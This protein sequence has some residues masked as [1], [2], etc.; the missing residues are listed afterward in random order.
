MFRESNL[1]V[2]K[3]GEFAGYGA[4]RHP[5]GSIDFNAYRKR[6]RQ[7]RAAAIKS[8]LSGAWSL[9]ANRLAGKAAP[10]AGRHATGC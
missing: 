5:D 7:A 9:L 10:A 6:A 2:P 8:L 1:D 4:L 3:S